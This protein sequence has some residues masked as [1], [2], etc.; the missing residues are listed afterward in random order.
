VTYP[1]PAVPGPTALTIITKKTPGS[2]GALMRPSAV[3]NGHPVPL[4]WGTNVIPARPGVHHIQ[5]YTQYLWK[6]GRAEITVDNTREPA[7]PV[8]Y[9]SPWTNFTKGAI[10]FQPVKNPGGL[11][12]GIFAGIV[13][14]LMLLI[15]IGGSLSSNG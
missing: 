11:A 12:V 7:N 10:A 9:A 4:E 2:F 8:Y 1:T 5:L 14:V 3:I 13:V 15:C 6:I